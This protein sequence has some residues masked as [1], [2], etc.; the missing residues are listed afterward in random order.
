MSRTPRKTKNQNP[1]GE[2]IDTVELTPKQAEQAAMAAAA[3]R[4]KAETIGRYVAMFAMPLIIVGMMVTGNL[5]TMHAPA[6]HNMPIAVVVDATAGSPAASEF[7]RQLEAADPAAIDVRIVDSAETARQLVMDRDVSGAVSIADGGATVFTASSAGASQS[8]VVTSLVAPQILAQGLTLASED[9][10]PL[11]TNDPAGLGALFLATALVMAGYLPF[12]MV[13]SNS[14][15]LLRFKRA[16][17][18]LA[19]WAALV[20]SLVWTVTGPILGVVEGH[21]AAVLGIAW[22][23]VFAIGSVQLLLT[24]FLGPMATLAAMLF[25]NVLGMPASNMSMSVYTMPGFFTFLHSILPTPAIGEALRSVLYFEGEGTAAHLLVL[26]IGGVA[27][28]LST[29][30]VD[31]RRRRRKPQSTGPKPTIASLHGGPRPKSRRMRYGALLLLP[32]AMVTMMISVMLGAMSSPAPRDMPVAIVGTT[33]AQAQQ[34]ADGLETNMP[35][36]FDL[37]PVDSTSEARDQVADRDITAA[38]VLPSAENPSAT[39]ITN[40]AGSSS[41]KQVVT[42]VFEQVA[43]G[44]QMPLVTEELAPLKSNDTSGSV[45]MY[46]AMGWMLAGFMI[47]IV[48]ANAAPQSRPLPRLLP[49]VGVYAAFMSAVLYLIAGPITG[50]MDDHFWPIFGIGAVA[51][52]CVAMFSAVLER[53]MGMFSIIPVVG[54]LVMAGMPSSGGALS[55][56][57]APDIFRVLHGI[58]P[59][60]AAVESIRSVL[61]FGADT[62]P[63]H[64]LTFGIWGAASLGLLMI[65]D[66]IKPPRTELHPIDGYG[67]VAPATEKE[68]VSV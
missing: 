35:G 31:A 29:L 41:A 13:V 22:L 33:V 18:L 7:A 58:L 21:T 24:R 11:P 66:K 49:V 47:I 51:I 44:Q 36:L 59:M 55:I 45:G 23:G 60:P 65:I 34:A 54:I 4:A 1:D 12:S 32:L 46:L 61:Y 64:L 25:L 9:L 63:G 38:Y 57:M 30:L 8:T 68:L 62:V 56:Y 39:M 10:A 48:G 40:Q 5:G 15:E 6:P 3:K 52:F 26:V 19:G 16:I 14:P 27:A 43:A 37:R 50:S 28:L 53:L 67:P 20:A 42:R 2:T 17:P